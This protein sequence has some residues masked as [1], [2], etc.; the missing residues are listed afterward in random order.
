MGKLEKDEQKDVIKYCKAN[1][2]PVVASLNGV[3][4]GGSRSKIAI[5]INSLKSQGMAVGFPD[6]MMFLKDKIL[7]IELKRVKDYVIK[8]NQREWIDKINAYEYADAIICHGA[9]EAIKKIEE[10]LK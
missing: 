2:I 7:F 6:L 4:I 5:T 9:E 8:D 10:C 3:N 1:K